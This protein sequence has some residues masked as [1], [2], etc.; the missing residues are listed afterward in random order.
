MWQYWG[1]VIQYSFWQS[2]IWPCDKQR[3]SKQPLLI[4][5][6]LTLVSSALF[7][8][9]LSKLKV[10]LCCFPKIV[11]G[12]TLPTVLLVRRVFLK[13]NSCVTVHPLSHCETSKVLLLKVSGILGGI[14]CPSSESLS[15]YSVWSLPHKTEAPSLTETWT[16]PLFFLAAIKDVLKVAFLGYFSKHHFSVLH[17]NWKGDLCHFKPRSSCVWAGSPIYI[18]SVATIFIALVQ[19]RNTLKCLINWRYECLT[20]V[21]I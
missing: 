1:V 14:S 5:D 2:A 19:K 13:V 7:V 20:I 9:P 18:S 6:S 3:V 15:G 12:K 16:V 10:I 17:A 8:L 11:G 21:V 4:M